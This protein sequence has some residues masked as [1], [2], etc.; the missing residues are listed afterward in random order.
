MTCITLH[1]LCIQQ[2]DPYNPRW[3]LQDNK[4]NLIRND[5]AQAE[6]GNT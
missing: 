2:S 6:D 3:R 4:L 5:D 1:N